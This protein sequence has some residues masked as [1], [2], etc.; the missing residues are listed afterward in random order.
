VSHINSHFFRFRR[1]ESYVRL[2]NPQFLQHFCYAVC[3]AAKGHFL[4]RVRLP[5]NR[6]KV[7]LIVVISSGIN[8]EGTEAFPFME[9]ALE[10]ISRFSHN[11]RFSESDECKHPRTSG[12][13]GEERT[14]I[15]HSLAEFVFAFLY[16][17]NGVIYHLS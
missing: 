14:W 10:I 5:I 4:A 13:G 8:A 6:Q 16:F 15:L 9:R 7:Y 2:A 3:I 1:V 17:R 12:I 11:R